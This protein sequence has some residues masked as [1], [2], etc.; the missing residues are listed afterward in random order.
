MRSAVFLLPL[1]ALPAAAQ[2]KAELPRVLLLGDSIRLGYAPI[3]AKKLAGVAEVVSPEQNGGDSANLLRHADDWLAKKPDIVHFN[4]G[5][6]DLKFSPK[7]LTHQVPVEQYGDNLKAIVERLQAGKAQVIFANTTPI[8]DERH[9]ARKAGFDRLDAD[10]RAY[11]AKAVSVVLPLGVVVNDLYAI[12]RDGGPAKMLG[13][14]GTHYTREGYERLADAV[15]DSIRRQ[16]AVRNPLRL[17]TPAAGPEAVAA[18]R[19]VESLLDAD[20]PAAIKSLPFPTFDPPKSADEWAKR[21]PDVKAKVV[22][23]LGDLPP[24]PAKPAAHLVSAEIRP[25]YRLERLRIDN[26]VDGTMSALLLVPDGLKGPAPTILWLHS[27]SYTHTQLLTPNMNGGEEPLGETFV[28]RGYVVLAP[29]AAWYG[30]RAGQGPAGP[31]ETTANQQTSQMKLNLW[32]GRTLWGMFV[33]DDQVALDYLCTRKEVDPKRFGATGISMGST[34][35]WWLAA[36]DDRVAA[37]VGVACLTRY[38]NLIKHGQLR[39]HGV[40]YF[41]NGLLKHFDTEAVVSLIAPRP[42][43]FLTGELDAGSPADGIKVIEPKAGAVYEAVGAGGK[44]KSIRYPDVGHMYT[45]AMRAEMLAWF[46]K[47]LKLK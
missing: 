24:R 43:L 19:K 34:R 10:V 11:N 12:V 9:A 2:P 36:V 18:F 46:E 8:L 17:A 23:S 31:S 25:G 20:V 13:Q 28:K 7:T 39:Q 35:S 47:W 5:L 3:V 15:A 14:D 33:R 21:R 38:E 41:V 45:P 44:F 1:L 42:V 22:A 40:Y 32:F 30:D 27:S 26:G 6:H 29:D 4:C 16:L 37:V